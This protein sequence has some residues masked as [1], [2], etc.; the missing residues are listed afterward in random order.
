M[1]WLLAMGM[2][3]IAAIDSV[4]A[5]FPKIQQHQFAAAL[6]YISAVQNPHDCSWIT[7]YIPSDIYHGGGFASKFQLAASQFMFRFAYGKFQ[8]PV[9]VR[10]HLGGY[11]R[12]KECAN[13]KYGWTCFFLESSRCDSFLADAAAAYKNGTNTTTTPTA[14]MI[15]RTWV[16]YTRPQESAL[17]PPRFQHLGLPFWWGVVQHYLFRLQ[18]RVLDHIHSFA[19]TIGVMHSTR[20]F[21]I[22]SSTSYLPLIGL[23]VRHGD[24]YT[25]GFQ[26]HSLEEGLRLARNTT[27]CPIQSS[28]SNA[29]KGG[30]NCFLPATTL[31]YSS[32]HHKRAS[33]GLHPQVVISMENKDRYDQRSNNKDIVVKSSSISH[34]Q[35]QQSA[36]S[37]L[38]IPVSV[39]VASDDQAVIKAARG[40]GYFTQPLGSSHRNTSAVASSTTNVT[41]FAK[42]VSDNSAMAYNSSLEVISDIYFLSHCHVLV[43]MASS[44]VFRMA[45]AMSNASGL[46]MQARAVDIVEVPKVRE[47]SIRYKVPYYETFT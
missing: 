8:M 46:L 19:G 44:Q 21:P 6:R 14:I 32:N 10:G 42:V 22:S 27:I 26:E 34:H 45:V 35:K 15:D 41:A 20:S 38:V 23:H 43:G 12:G 24:K 29:N 7:R 2:T 36:A 5:S 39:F 31:H 17:I 33:A 4:T 16:N 37:S 47:M 18:P 25:D 28:S 13:A 30:I 11:S 1:Y 3:I 40:L 9:I